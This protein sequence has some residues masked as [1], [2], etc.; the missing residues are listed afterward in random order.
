MV[1]TTPIERASI[2]L[3][4]HGRRSI[5]TVRRDA[6]MGHVIGYC[7]FLLP[8][9]KR[10]QSRRR[11]ERSGPWLNCVRSWTHAPI[12]PLVSTS[13]TGYLAD[14]CRLAQR[15]RRG[16]DLAG[17]HVPGDGGGRSLACTASSVQL[18]LA[19]SKVYSSDMSTVH[20]YPQPCSCLLMARRWRVWAPARGPFF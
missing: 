7:S 6:R 11:P 3:P 19:W 12:R 13:L 2:P 8:P 5:M 1:D 15:F 16:A 18:R 9:R 10:R 14:S 20:S 4:Q 17:A